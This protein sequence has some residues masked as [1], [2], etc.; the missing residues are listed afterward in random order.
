MS[1]RPI[2]VVRNGVSEPRPDG[3]ER[4]RSDLIV[5]EDLTAALDGIEAYSHI[6]VVFFC[7]LVP[8]EERTALHI[9]PRGDP[10][11]PEQGVLATRSQRRPSALG[12]A[13]VPLLRR[14][15]NIL[16]VV[17]LDAID[18]T[19]VLD[20]KPYLPM[21]DSVPEARVPDWV[22]RPPPPPS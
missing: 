13:V 7:H 20:I 15:R 22:L 10:R 3:W 14:R 16:R 12:V 2:A 17:G 19:P 21:Y 18:G 4:V 5:R 8:E 11:L 6:I 1:L 9:H